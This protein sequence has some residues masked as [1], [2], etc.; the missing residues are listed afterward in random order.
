MKLS[1]KKYILFD[2]DGTLIDSKRGIFSA[3]YYTFERLGLREDDETVLNSFIGPSIGASFRRQ[4]GF[5]EIQ[6]NEAVEIYR[7]YY[8]EKGV[9]EYVLYD[10]IESLLIKL[11]A[12]GK[13]LGVAT[14]KPDNYAKLII[15]ELGFNQYFDLVCG[16]TLT[17]THDSKAHIIKECAEQLGAC[18]FDEVVMIGDTKYDCLGANEA[19]V[20]C[21]GVLYGYGCEDELRKHGA[22][23]IAVDM[24]DL[25][26]L[27]M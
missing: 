3:I 27:L 22:T 7:E 9:H 25:T 14:K 1:N 4:Y 8:S 24:T 6:A 23:E 10:G 20:D 17:E 5:S 12:D 11:K 18:S 16:S 13:T 26:K 15:K 19:G 2:L 21:I